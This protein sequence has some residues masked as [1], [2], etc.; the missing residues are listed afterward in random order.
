M[1]S[2]KIPKVRLAKP[3]K[4]PYQVRYHCPIEQREIRITTGTHDETEAEDKRQEVLAKLRLGIEAKPRKRVASGPNMAWSDFRNRYTTLELSRL[5]KNSRTSAE[6]RLELAER[7]LKPQRLR[8]VADSEALH[9]L[10]AQL[11]KGAEGTT[12]RG[13]SPHTV[14]SHMAAVM[15]ALNWAALMEYLP[16]V[17]KIRKVKVSKL[18]QMKGRPISESEF[19]QML[20]ATEEVV[21]EDAK[22]SWQYTMRGIWESGLRL[23]E[24]LNVSWDDPAFIMPVWITDAFPELS[25]PASMQKNDTEE[26]IPLLPGFEALLEE[27]PDH[28]RYGWVFNPMSLQGRLG[29]KVR[30]S[31]PTV[32]WASRVITRIGEEAGIVVEPKK[33]EKPAK[34]ASAHDLRRS[35]ADRLVAAGVDVRDVQAVLRHA[36]AET[37]RKYYTRTTTQR[38]ASAIRKIVTVPRYTQPA[39]ST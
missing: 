11:L 14:K 23:E 38:A 37:T 7:I 24:L 15:A 12:G 5:R 22:E 4:R 17:P 9:D 10:Q 18:K 31:R 35:C 33:G 25:I 20:D 28:E 29:R 34:Y 2:T 3:G 27:T 8:D 13:R 1:A 26:S 19:H 39:E 30:P 32:G 16:A 6:T 36:S 21:G